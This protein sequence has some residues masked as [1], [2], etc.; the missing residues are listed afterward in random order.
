MSAGTFKEGVFL[1]HVRVKPKSGANS[2][3]GV[4]EGAGGRQHLEMRVSSPP[5]DGEANEA[6]QRLIAKAAGVSRGSVSILSGERG[7]AKVLKINGDPERL[8]AWLEKIE[9]GRNL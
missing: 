3:L 1:L 5:R 2:I 7:R 4:R 6:V 8:K 9:A